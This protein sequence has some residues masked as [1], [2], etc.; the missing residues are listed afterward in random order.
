[1]NHLEA[2]FKGKNSFWRYAVM[3]AAVL[4]VSNTVGALP[5]L[6]A[7][8]LKAASNPAVMD[9]IAKNPSDFSVLGLNPN[10]ELFMMLF[11]F[12]AGLLAFVLLIKPLN[13]RTFKMTIN[14]TGKIRWERFF[15]SGAVW[16]VLSAAYL[17]IYL[18][19][20]PSNFS[21]DNTSASILIL[22]AI[23]LLLIPFQAFFEEILFRGYLMQ[24]FAVLSRNRWIP[25]IMTSVLFGLMHSFN[26][27]I[28]EFGFTDMMA[29]YVLFGLIFGIIT[30]TD[31][32][33]EAAAGAHAANNAFLCIMVTHRSSALQTPAVYEQV[34][35]YPWLEFGILLVSGIIFILILKRIFKW[36][37]FSALSGKVEAVSG[38]DQTPYT[39]VRSSLR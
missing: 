8:A 1:M 38:G 35:V 20:D 13:G 15:I 22:I 16:M 30:I 32:G 4:I 24:G 28:K 19:V 26:P 10:V 25:M 6:V 39:D 2:A 31:D 37:S 14:G 11:P 5:L 21:L 23:T 7:Y 33:I 12:L 34:R 18:K 17:F 9:S 3:F 36:K 29:Q 27:E